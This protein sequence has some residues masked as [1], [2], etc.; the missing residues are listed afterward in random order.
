MPYLYFC[1]DSNSVQQSV[2]FVHFHSSHTSSH[3]GG[4]YVYDVN[5]RV[6][7]TMFVTRVLTKR[8]WINDQNRYI[9]LSEHDIKYPKGCSSLTSNTSSSTVE[10]K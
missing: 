1:N 7:I 8:N 10:Y 9:A 5:M 4:L 3:H 6:C 2:Q